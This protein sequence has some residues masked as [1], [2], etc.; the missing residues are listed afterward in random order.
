[1][2][3]TKAAILKPLTFQPN[4][5]NPLLV[6]SVGD[7]QKLKTV[8][9]RGA[10]SVL[11][12]VS[13]L[14]KYETA[15]TFSYDHLAKGI[16]YA[17][18]KKRE[19]FVIIDAIV[20]NTDIHDI[21]RHV[22]TL[23]TLQPDACVVP[24]VAPFLLVKRTA[25]LIPLYIAEQAHVNNWVTAKFWRDFGAQHIMLANELTF[26]EVREIRAKVS[27]VQMG[28]YV[29]GALYESFAHSLFMSSQTEH[30]MSED[31]KKTLDSKDHMVKEDYYGTRMLATRDVCLL[32]FMDEI[33][34]AGLNTVAIDN[35]ER[36]AVYLATA[37]QGYRQ[38]INFLI[39]SGSNLNS[40][41][42]FQRKQQLV[43]LA[44]KITA[45]LQQRTD[46]EFTFGFM[47]RRS[48]YS[49]IAPSSS[50]TTPSQTKSLSQ[51]QR[52]RLV[53]TKAKSR[54][55]AIF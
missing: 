9:D 32:R 6:T 4:T 45:R 51:K 49:L 21:R 25:P 22:K 27:D 14:T 17:H 5:S 41:R 52:T 19:V 34:D 47:F 15:P 26:D 1:M 11:C 55:K 31:L 43:R 3:N 20:H 39:K 16:T 44:N 42:K 7:L 8:I 40:Q 36:D 29:Q 24:R 37:T 30:G 2:P 18:S 38:V 13:N 12:R 10:D 53:K 28:I 50:Q 48:D 54:S 23:A 46:R 33:Y 35:P